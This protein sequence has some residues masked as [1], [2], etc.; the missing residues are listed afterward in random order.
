MRNF[1]HGTHQVVD[2]VVAFT[3]GYSRD[4]AGK[5]LPDYIMKGILPEDP[6]QVLDREGV[7]HLVEMAV[8]KGRKARPD[9][10]NGI[11]GEHG[12]EPASV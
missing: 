7:G 1:N 2:P 12:G 11:C 4:I 6:F 8:E 3:F 9:I 5:F 10:H